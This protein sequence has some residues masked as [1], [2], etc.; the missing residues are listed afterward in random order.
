MKGYGHRIHLGSQFEVGFWL[1]KDELRQ[2][3]Y[4]LGKKVGGMRARMCCLLFL[5]FIHF[6]KLD[7]SS[8]ID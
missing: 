1:L 4:W 8:R 6:G 2:V 7:S 3:I 5:D